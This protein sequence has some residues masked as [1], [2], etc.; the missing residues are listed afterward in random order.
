[1]KKYIITI[2]LSLAIVISLIIPS[3]VVMAKEGGNEESYQSIYEK[4]D[5]YD[6]IENEGQDK[7]EK[8]EEIQNQDI[9]EGEQENIAPQ[10]IAEDKT[11]NIGEEFDPKTDVTATDKDGN[12]ITKNIEILENTVDI[13]TIGKYIVTYSVKDSSNLESRKTIYVTVKK[14]C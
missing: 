10:I 11:I 6:E 1:M 5:A 12:D 3:R 14:R 9:E 2:F 13:N 7:E 8:K 4:N